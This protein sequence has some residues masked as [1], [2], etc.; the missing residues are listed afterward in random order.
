MTAVFGEVFKYL[1]EVFVTTLRLRV[2]KQEN[3]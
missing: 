2:N 1:T 3:Q